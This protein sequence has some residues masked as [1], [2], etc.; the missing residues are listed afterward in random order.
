MDSFALTTSQCLAEALES[1]CQS[2]CWATQ[3]GAAG[4]CMPPAWGLPWQDRDAF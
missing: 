2:S 4:G 3:A 1:E